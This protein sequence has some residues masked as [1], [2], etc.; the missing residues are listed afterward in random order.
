MPAE[1]HA[2]LTREDAHDE[3]TD[4][5][6]M[7]ATTALERLRP[8]LLPPAPMKTPEP[9]APAPE[10]PPPAPEPRPEVTAPKPKAPPVPR[11]RGRAPE[12]R[13]NPSK[14]QLKLVD[15]F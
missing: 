5:L 12:G 2:V 11:H 15:P 3:H 10:T 8:V 14:P 4:D 13:A 6:L 7:A 9:A 1:S